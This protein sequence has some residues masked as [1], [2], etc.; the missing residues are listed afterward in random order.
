MSTAAAGT[1]IVKL[2]LAK[3]PSVDETAGGVAVFEVME[4]SALQS[5]NTLSPIVVTAVSVIEVIA[6]FSKALAPISVTVFGKVNAP[7]KV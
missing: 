5:L 6:V 1:L 2:A 4:D 3:V 7:A